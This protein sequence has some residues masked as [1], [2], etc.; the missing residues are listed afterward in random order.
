MKK[1][2]QTFLGIHFDF[3]ALRDYKIGGKYDEKQIDDFLS[4]VKPDFIQVDSK[5]HPGVASFPTPYGM[6]AQ[7]VEDVM[8][9]WRK[10]TKKHDVALLAHYFFSLLISIIFLTV[11]WL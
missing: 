3:H 6:H 2:T 10:L 9:I 4:R 8:P 5:G 7:I 1:R 11:L